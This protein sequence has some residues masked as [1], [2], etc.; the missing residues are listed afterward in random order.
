MKYYHVTVMCV[1][2]CVAP[3]SPSTASLSSLMELESCV[4]N[5]SLAHEIVVNGEFCFKA[6]G[7]ASDRREHKHHPNY[8]ITATPAALRRFSLFRAAFHPFSLCSLENRVTQI[9][10][11]AF[12]DGLQEQLSRDPPDYKHA[13]VLLQEIKTVG[14]GFT[15]GEM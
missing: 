13:V 10:H 4:S 5:L 7:P 8:T 3:G 1:C 11:R 6:R 15:D 14:E 12:W 9:V 2:V